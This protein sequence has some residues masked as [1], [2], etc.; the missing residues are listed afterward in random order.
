MVNITANYK[1]N[2]EIVA[3]MIKKYSKSFVATGTLVQTKS[4]LDS[5]SCKLAAACSS[6]AGSAA[7]LSGAKKI[8]HRN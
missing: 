3:P 5:G 8:I 7:K 4:K 6:G 2:A 1:V